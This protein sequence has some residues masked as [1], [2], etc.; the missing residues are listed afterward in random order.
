MVSSVIRGHCRELEFRS[1]ASKA[2]VFFAVF[3][4]VVPNASDSRTEFD[5][6]S[7]SE[8]RYCREAISEFC[9]YHLHLADVETKTE[10]SYFSGVT[11]S[12][13]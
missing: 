7:L 13:R 1:F 9:C 2:R 4:L 8:N 12:G 11:Q 6:R 10:V 5:Q 3:A